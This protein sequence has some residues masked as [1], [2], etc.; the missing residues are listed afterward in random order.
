MKKEGQDRHRQLSDWAKMDSGT[1]TPGSG[2]LEL[3]SGRTVQRGGSS[4]DKFF[5]PFSR[6]REHP[7]RRQAG[8][9]Q[10]SGGDHRGPRSVKRE[11]RLTESPEETREELEVRSMESERPVGLKGRSGKAKKKHLLTKL[12]TMLEEALADSGEEDSVEEEQPRRSVHE[13]EKLRSV[14]T[15]ELSLE[16]NQLPPV[17]AV[18]PSLQSDLDYNKLLKMRQRP[19]TFSGK[20]QSVGAWFNAME[21][22]FRRMSTPDDMRLWVA[23]SFLEGD[24]LNWYMSVEA[25][26]GFSGWES[27]SHKLRINYGGVSPLRAKERLRQVRMTASLEEYIAEFNRLRLDCMGLSV[28]EEVEMFIDGLHPEIMKLMA[29]KTPATKEEAIELAHMFNDTRERIDRWRRAGNESRGKEWKS[30]PGRFFQYERFRPLRTEAGRDSPKAL[31]PDSLQRGSRGLQGREWKGTTKVTPE[32]SQTTA[33]A[34]KATRAD[35]GR[36]QGV[37]E[38][39]PLICW[40]CGKEGHPR[41]LCR[42]PSN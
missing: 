34:Q 37:A 8:E 26:G 11:D 28:A 41:A 20:G 7:E 2:V 24:A 36:Q 39:K 9:D 42:E 30:R 38:K 6:D 40:K 27:F 10:L 25:A 21:L 12:L 16:Q 19:Q 31:G 3:R 5:V 29:T 14:G 18:R 23:E 33:G 13:G 1:S 17:H 22:F 15:G 35:W 4:R 32:R